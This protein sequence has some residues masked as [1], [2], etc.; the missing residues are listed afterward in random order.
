MSLAEITNLRIYR[1]DGRLFIEANTPDRPVAGLVMEHAAM[2]A[3]TLEPV[4]QLQEDHLSVASP[5]ISGQNLVAIVHFSFSTDALN[6]QLRNIE[7]D[8]KIRTGG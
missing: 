6:A 2:V 5:I 4:L 3:E 7:V 8:P 1:P